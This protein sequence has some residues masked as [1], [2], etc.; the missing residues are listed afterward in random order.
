MERDLPE[1]EKRPQYQVLPYVKEIFTRHF[2]RLI[3]YDDSHFRAIFKSSYFVLPEGID[4]P[5][6]SQWGTLKKKMKRHHKGV[7]VFK[8]TGVIDCGGE[9]GNCYYVDFGFFA[10]G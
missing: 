5:S 8:E 2:V 7:F 1:F 4:E 9:Q 3:E 6:K 10:Y